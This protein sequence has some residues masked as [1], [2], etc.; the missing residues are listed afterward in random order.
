LSKRHFSEAPSSKK[1]RKAMVVRPKIEFALLGADNFVSWSMMAKAYFRACGVEDCFECSSDGS[2]DEAVISLY[3]VA[4]DILLSL[5][6]DRYIH[7][8]RKEGVTPLEAWGALSASWRDQAVAKKTLYESQLHSLIMKPEEQMVAFV[9][10]GIDILLN[11]EATGAKVDHASLI[12]HLIRGL[13]STYDSFLLGILNNREV[14][15]DL[16]KVTAQL[17]ITEQFITE[18]QSQLQSGRAFL[19]KP[20]AVPSRVGM[21]DRFSRVRRYFRCNSLN[22]LVADCPHPDHRPHAQGIGQPPT[23]EDVPIVGMAA[24]LPPG[25]GSGI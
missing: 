4:L 21:G 1:K 13:P 10:R 23:V 18:R 9:Q 20:S 2:H 19:A 7:V 6:E 11:I 25:F 15:G 8:L 17:L 22:H 12:P 3:P 14:M 16:D 24:H 5:V